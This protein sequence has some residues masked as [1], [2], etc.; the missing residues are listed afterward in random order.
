VMWERVQDCYNQ[1]LPMCVTG[2]PYIV[3][4]LLC[5]LV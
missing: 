3:I 2:I 4:Q 1:M 5:S